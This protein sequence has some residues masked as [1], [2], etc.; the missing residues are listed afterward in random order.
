M[1]KELKMGDQDLDKDL[2]QDVFKKTDSLFK[3]TERQGL[4]TDKVSTA[5]LDKQYSPLIVRKYQME[6]WPL[7]IGLICDTSLS[8]LDTVV[9]DCINQNKY[10]LTNDIQSIRN[11]TGVIS[12][13]LLRH[14]D[15]EK[16]GVVEGIAV[17]YYCDKM[18][19]SSLW[20]D[21]MTHESCKMELY[22]I[23]QTLPHI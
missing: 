10:L 5:L 22:S 14:Y 3:K 19:V 23:L 4:E 11:L 2:E 6:G 16:T 20:G 1:T 13:Y 18:M 7:F 21:F 15:S 9:W 8:D 12:E 17:I